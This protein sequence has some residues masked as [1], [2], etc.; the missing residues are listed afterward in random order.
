MYSDIPPTKPEREQADALLNLIVQ[1]ALNSPNG[2]GVEQFFRFEVLGV[3]YSGSIN[4]R[5][6][7]RLPINKEDTK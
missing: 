2:S 4:L 3:E 1:T 6:R 7:Q 5:W